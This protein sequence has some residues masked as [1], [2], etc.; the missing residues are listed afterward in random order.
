M[1]DET[2][3][4]LH[5]SKPPIS[6][7]GLTAWFRSEEAQVPW[8]S[9][10]GSHQGQVVSQK[11]RAGR[12]VRVGRIF[13]W[14]MRWTTQLGLSFEIGVAV[15]KAHAL[16]LALSSSNAWDQPSSRITKDDS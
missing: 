1:D 6:L 9:M 3:E 16:C 11:A 13:L 4:H 2:Y 14:A 10:V 15:W 5:G 7:E 12:M 8:P